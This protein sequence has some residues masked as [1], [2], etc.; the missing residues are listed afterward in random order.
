MN[1]DTAHARELDHLLREYL[2]EGHQDNHIRGQRPEGL[3]EIRVANTLR[4]NDGQLK[5]IRHL[6][7]GRRLELPSSTL[8]P[9]RLG[10]DADDGMT[11]FGEG[12]KGRVGEFRRTHEKNFRFHFTHLRGIGFDRM[13]TTSGRFFKEG[14]T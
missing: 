11:A 2:T 13:I 4:L 5:A 6:L 3:D 8:G 7:D 10:D 9:I 14:T 12:F 1:I